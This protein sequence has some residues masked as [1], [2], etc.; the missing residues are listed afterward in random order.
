MKLIFTA[1]FL[2][3]YFFTFAQLSEINTGLNGI[4]LAEEDYE[5]YIEKHK[6][7]VTT[8]SLSEKQKYSRARI[9]YTQPKDLFLLAKNGVVIDH[10]KHKQNVFIESD[11][12]E[13]ELAVARGLGL[14]VQIIIDDVKAHYVAQNNEQELKS[15]EAKNLGCTGSSGGATEYNTPSNWSLGSMGGYFTYAE[16]MAHLDNMAALYPSLITTKAP[17]GSFQTY[18]S[19]PIYWLRMSDNAS[20]DEAEP[21]MLYSAIHHAR[22]PACLSQ[23]IFYMWYLLENYGSNSEVTAILDNTELYFVPLVN[24]DGYVYNEVNDPSGGGMWRKNRRNNGGGDY[25]VDNNRNYS[26]EWGTT[27]ISTN[28]GN[29]TYCGTAPFSESENQAMK[30]L[31]EQRNF[32][33]ALNS[34]TS[35]DLL[36]YPHGYNPVLT[37]DNATFEAISAMMVEQNGFNNILSADLYPASGDSDDWMYT[38]TSTHNKIYAMTPEIGPSFWP[39]ASQIEDICKSTVY[40]NLTAAHLITNYANVVDLNPALWNTTSGFLNY[41]IQRLGLQDPANFTITFTGLTNI[42]FPSPIKTHNGMALLQTDV[43]SVAYDLAGGIVDGDLIE[44]IINLNN[45]QFV[46]SDT[47]TKTYGNG[48][49]I[50]ADDAASMSNWTSSDWNTTS[51]E[52]HSPASS[53]TDSPGSGNDYNNNDVNTINL[54]NTINLTGAISAH[55]SFWAKW[56]IEAG[57]DYTQLQVSTDGGTSWIPQCG[58]YTSTGSADQDQGNPLWDGTQNTWVKEEIDLSDYFGQVIQFRFQ[59]VSDNWV[60]G[61][62]FYFDDFEVTTVFASVEINEQNTNP[63][64]ISQN[65]PNPSSGYTYINYHIPSTTA[66]A[67]LNITNA[68]GQLIE[69]I[70]LNPSSRSTLLNTKR[71]SPGNYLYFIQADQI[72]SASKRMVILN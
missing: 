45:G 12:S 59:L 71:L 43:D 25:G 70:K 29:D 55:L 50:F 72:R 8:T 68:V 23:L 38:E 2:T 64:Q 28:P 42:S 13:N 54:D 24:P 7:N 22:E 46:L 14:K 10:G 5:L 15:L 57:Y 48:T 56:E 37:P 58:N 44:Y 39:A 21:E 35:G 30:W 17:I 6:I 47:I 65:M 41:Q 16:V 60:T 49:V 26:Y 52:Y 3:S 51:L 53:I 63:F 31:C 1:F 66:D 32:V 34:H 27:G 33:M 40:M 67:S 18:E 9:F 61:D 19:R 69:K 11:Y 62:G 4:E 20:T 36:L